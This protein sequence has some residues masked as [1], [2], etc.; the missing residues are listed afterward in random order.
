MYT[1]ALKQNGSFKLIT[2]RNSI[3][4]TSLN[5]NNKINVEK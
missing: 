4:I 2:I 1:A 3:N 5:Q